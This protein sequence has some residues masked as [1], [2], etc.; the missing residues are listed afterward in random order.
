MVER[1]GILHLDIET[2]ATVDLPKCGV[3]RYVKCPDFE[4]LMCSYSFDDGPE[5]IVDLTRYLWPEKLKAAILSPKYLK[6]A[7]NAAFERRCLSQEFG[8]ELA[9]DD[10]ECTAVLSGR[11]GYPLSLGAAAKAMGLVQQKDKD[12]TSLINLF[13]KRPKKSKKNPTGEF[14]ASHLFPEKWDKFMSY[15]VQDTVVEKEIHKKVDYF[16]VSDFERNLWLL[17]QKINDR[18][19]RVDLDFVEAALEVYDRYRATILDEASELTGLANPNSPKQLMA[20][21]AE[22]GEEVQNLTKSTVEDL[23]RNLKDGDQTVIKRVLKLR[24]ELSKTSI[25]KYVAMLNFMD[26]KDHRCRGLFQFYGANRTGRFAGRAIQLQNLPQNKLLVDKKQ[27]IDDLGLARKLVK[28]R[29][30]YKLESLYDNVPDVLA[31]LIRTALVPEEGNRFLVCDFSAIE[32][33]IIAWLANE[34]WRLEAF[35][36]GVDIYIASASQMFSIPIDQIDKETPYGKSLRQRG[37]VAE[38]ACG[39]QGSTGALIRMGALLYGI[40]EV[41]LQGIVDAWRAASPAVVQLWNNLNNCAIKSIRNPGEKINSVKNIQFIS[42]Y[43]N[44]YI[45][46]PSGRYLSYIGATLVTNKWGKPSVEYWGMNQT[47]KT[48][49][50]QSTYGGKFA[51]NVTQAIARDCLAEA[52]VRLDNKGYDQAIHVHD[53]IVADMPFGKGSIEEMVKIMGEPIAWAPGL[54]VPAEGFETKYYKKD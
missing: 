32:A 9:A 52:M 12:G 19:V 38:L 29:D 45:K 33:R 25:K 14:N 44:L 40:K 18:G 20:W 34:T 49:E 24:Q 42:L 47:K 1:I 35:A 10:W 50:K 36:K 7:H 17:D 8:V 13:S 4:V 53:E 39:Y 41:E 46:L 23:M 30:L 43:D 21:L 28:N 2:K 31:Q 16:P 48:W 22:N 54:Y 26:D 11:A 27:S 6:V 3:H 37:K 15:C 51:E 5:K